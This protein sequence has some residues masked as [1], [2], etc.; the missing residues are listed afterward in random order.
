MNRMKSIS[1]EE[2][3]GGEWYGS[4]PQQGQQY[5][6]Q[7]YQ[8][9]QDQ[10]LNRQPSLNSKWRLAS[11][12]MQGGSF[13]RGTANQNSANSSYQTNPNMVNEEPSQHLGAAGEPIKYLIVIQ[14][15]QEEKLFLAILS[16]TTI[17]LKLVKQVKVDVNLRF[18]NRSHPRILNFSLLYMLQNYVYTHRIMMFKVYTK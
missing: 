13:R 5:P 12:H 1:L 3:D 8:Q 11:K 10:R 17:R 6:S 2:V 7:Q 4:Q 16:T 15:P 18:F 14:K 9:P